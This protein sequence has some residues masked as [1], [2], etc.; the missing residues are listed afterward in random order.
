MPQLREPGARV[1]ALA[2]DVIGAA[3]EVHRHLGPGFQES[4]YEEALCVELRLRR[5][6]FERQRVTRVEYKGVRVGEGRVDL[7]V[8]DQL[9]LEL[10]AVRE[11]APA[12][13]AV[14]L[15][16]LKA[17]DLR[18]GLLINFGAARLKDGIKRVVRS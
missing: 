13:Q 7:L 4:V 5:I 1:D 8:A 2:H 10:K 15:S 14:L 3:I 11:L 16:Y 12:H 17:T 9:V 18:L 6:P